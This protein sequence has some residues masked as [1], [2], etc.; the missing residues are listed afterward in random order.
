MRWIRSS[1]SSWGLLS[2]TVDR[3]LVMKLPPAIREENSPF[4]LAALFPGPQKLLGFVRWTSC[5]C[6]HCG[7]VFRRDFW[8]E[9]LQMGNGERLCSGCGQCFDD[10]SREW[11]ELTA[12]QKVR[13]FVPPLLIGIWGGFAL[14]GI[15]VYFAGPRDEHSLFV[16]L[17]SVLVG[18]IPVILYSPFH[19]IIVSR[20]KQRYAASQSREG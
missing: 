15:I 14:A 20:S 16:I 9:K 8:P 1:W 3:P 18:A 6:P 2:K 7:E 12:G 5:C 10:G 11:P 17:F 4:G 13:V 19:A